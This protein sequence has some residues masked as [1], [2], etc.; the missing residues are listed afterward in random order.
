MK[1]VFMGTPDFAAGV[2]ETIIKAG[3]E[4]T[5]VVTQ[6]DKPK[7][8]SGKPV[9]SPVK[10]V[11][12]KYGL[13]VFQPEKLKTPESVERLFLFEADLYVV[14]AYG[15]M[16]SQEILDHPRLGC[17]NIHASL[18]PKYRGAAPIQWAII[19]GEKVSGVTI[20]QME[21]GMDTGDILFTKEYELAADETGESLFERLC[22]CSKELILEALPKIEAGDI[23]PVKQDESLAT[24]VGMLSKSMGNLDFS[25]P[26]EE[27]ERLVRGLNSWPCAYTFY[28]GKNLKIW[29][30]YVAEGE[31]N[32]EPGSVAVVTKDTICVNTGEGLL[33]LKSVQ[34]EGKKR[35]DVKDFLLGN[36]VKVQDVFERTPGSND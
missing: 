21:L 13:P 9:Y 19:N 1:I 34:L 6:A 23:H 35:M 8:R 26:A 25:K 24:H 11:A 32:G 7:G 10:E 3:Y 27:L 18:L 12:I 20:Q 5:G 15:K 22:E 28:E 17:I 2:L 29:E 31:A 16:L 30:S 33:G 14:V 4:V 36:H